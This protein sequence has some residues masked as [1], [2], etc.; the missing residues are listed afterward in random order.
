MQIVMQIYN[1]LEFKAL[2]VKNGLLYEP[3]QAGWGREGRLIEEAIN[4]L[5][6]KFYLAFFRAVLRF[7]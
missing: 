1:S 7:S 3:C 6:W 2:K 5:D 4:F